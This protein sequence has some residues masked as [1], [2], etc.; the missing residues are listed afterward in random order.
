MKLTLKRIAKRN[1]YTIGRLFI[2]GTYFCDTLEDT[3]RGLDNSMPESEIKRIKIAGR[4]AIPTGTY[5]V[6]LEIQSPR[7]S[8]PKY[9]KQYGFCD[10]YLP[11]L[12]NV[13]GYD[14]VLIHIGNK[15]T[16]TDGCLLVGQNKKTGEVLNSTATFK[17]LYE[18]LKST[19]EPITIEIK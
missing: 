15:H 16:D 3:N 8:K 12:L 13:K 6:T 18:I 17:R 9:K 19:N 4:T 7:F 5:S 11:R 14:G 2:D 10:G 1:D